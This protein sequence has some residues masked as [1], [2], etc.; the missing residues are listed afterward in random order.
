[1][2]MT[3]TK[4][5]KRAQQNHGGQ[6]CCGFC[7]LVKIDVESKLDAYWL[8]EDLMEALPDAICDFYDD[9]FQ[10]IK[11]TSALPLR[12]SEL[13][14]VFKHYKMEY[15]IVD[16]KKTRNEAQQSRSEVLNSL[17]SLI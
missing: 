3:V 9:S 11:I 8:K 13:K 1:M 7:Y 6:P 5:T 2:E 10:Y 4:E 14:S 16:A 12:V 17:L 15:S